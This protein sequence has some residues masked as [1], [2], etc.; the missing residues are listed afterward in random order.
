MVA[1]EPQGAGAVE[2][3]RG[4]DYLRVRDRLE[5]ARVV[6]NVRLSN[7]FLKQVFLGPHRNLRIQ[8]LDDTILTTSSDSTYTGTGTEILMDA[9]EVLLLE[10]DEQTHIALQAQNIN[11]ARVRLV[12]W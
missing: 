12:I 3:A 6:L 5:R 8:S 4:L 11:G 9:G 2:S 1:R 10:N 7:L